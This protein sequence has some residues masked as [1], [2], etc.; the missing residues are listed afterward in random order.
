MTRQAFPLSTP[1]SMIGGDALGLSCKGTKADLE[2]LSISLKDGRELRVSDGDLAATGIV[3][4]LRRWKVEQS[5]STRIK[6]R[7]YTLCKRRR[8]SEI[9]HPTT[10]QVFFSEPGS[11]FHF[12]TTNPKRT[13]DGKF[14]SYPLLKYASG[15]YHLCFPLAHIWDVPDVKRPLSVH[16]LL[17]TIDD[18]HHNHAIAITD[19]LSYPTD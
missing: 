18:A 3:N 4:G 14:D 9:A 16:F 7:T 6:S 5:S 11:D 12:D 13:T 17:N 15:G 19:R 2:R 10:L 1:I 8:G